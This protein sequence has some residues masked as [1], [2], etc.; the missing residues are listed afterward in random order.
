MTKNKQTATA[1]TQNRWKGE[2][3]PSE[4]SPLY[5]HPGPRREISVMNHLFL[6]YQYNNSDLVLKA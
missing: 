1:G 3:S 2:V 6:I 5:P 4:N